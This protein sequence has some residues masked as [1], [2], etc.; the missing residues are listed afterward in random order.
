MRAFTHPKFRDV[1]F[2]VKKSFFVA[3][4]NIWKLKIIWMSKRHRIEICKEN[5][6]IT[7]EKYKELRLYREDS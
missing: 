4:K 6:T 3:E 5:I 7:A 2:L 1:Y